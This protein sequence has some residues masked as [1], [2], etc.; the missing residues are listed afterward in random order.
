VDSILP[1]ELPKV[2]SPKLALT[3]P[4]NKDPALAKAMEIIRKLYPNEDWSN[5]DISIMPMSDKMAFSNTFG[6]TDQFNDKISINPILNSIYPSYNNLISTLV[7]ELEH[8]RQNQR[9][10]TPENRVNEY[11]KESKI[12][13]MNR[14]S[15]LGARSVTNQIFKSPLFPSEASESQWKLADQLKKFMGITK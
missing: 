1:S 9:L 7:H 2:S 4:I 3:Q 5:Q 8:V 6:T 11:V 14:P 10:G 12:P 13:Y 15:E